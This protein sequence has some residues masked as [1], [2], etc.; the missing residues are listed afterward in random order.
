MDKELLPLLLRALG[1]EIGIA[2]S[3]STPELLRSKLYKIRKT[4]PDFEVLSFVIPNPHEL[5]I[6]KRPEN[7]NA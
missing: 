5:F 4:D 7:S 1:S 2:V 6:V 3:C